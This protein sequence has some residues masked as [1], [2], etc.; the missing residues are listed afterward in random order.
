MERY[1]FGMVGRQPQREA[2]SENAESPPRALRAALTRAQAESTAQMLSVVS[3]PVRLQILS[4][5]HHSP[6]GL[7]RVVDLTEALE[8]RQPTVSHHLKVMFEAGILTREPVG[9]EAWYGIVAERLVAISDLL[10]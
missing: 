7:A 1:A 10:R 9:R 4:L 5:I 8:L 2:W 6:G 3:N